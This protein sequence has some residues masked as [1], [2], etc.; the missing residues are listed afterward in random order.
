M[1]YLPDTSEGH[2]DG[3]KISTI[4]NCIEQFAPNAK[5]IME[6]GFNGGHSADAFLSY[7]SH[8]QLTSFDLGE[9][10][11]VKQGKE[12]INHYYPNRHT[13]LL[14]NSVETVP[15]FQPM[16]KY[17]VIFIDGGH[18]YATARSD[19]LNCKRLAH[20]ETLVLM[21][22]TMK[23]SEWVKHWNIGPNKA[24]ETL[25]QEGV[26][27]ELGYKDYSRGLGISWGKYVG[28]KSGL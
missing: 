19:I 1:Y 22:D 27:E 28:I 24:W 25:A 20:S 21:D 14:G 4:Y 9:H 10:E 26:V 12:Y 6:I 15:I 13:L 23:Q 16:Y 7:R 11:Y 5:Y 8:I 18:D 17:D 2:I 3:H